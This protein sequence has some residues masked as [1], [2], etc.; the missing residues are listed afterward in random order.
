MDPAVLRRSLFDLPGVVSAQPIDAVVGSMRDVVSQLTDILGV[1][2]L[3]ALLLAVLVAYNSASISQDERTRE[4]AT[5]LAFGL[6]ARRVMGASVIE[7]GLIGLLGTAMGMV[8]GLAAVTW[9]VYG[10][11]PSSMPDFGL[12]PVISPGTLLVAVGLGIVA[13]S[14]APLLTWRRLTRMNLPATLRVVE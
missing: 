4:V 9:L 8:G 1:V 10:L 3:I 5:M 7:S 11:L 13:V 12:D 14:L 6:P 2:A